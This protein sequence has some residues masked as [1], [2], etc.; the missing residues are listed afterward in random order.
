[1]KTKVG[2]LTLILLITLYSCN[3]SSDNSYVEKEAVINIDIAI[4]TVN[5]ENLKSELNLSEQEYSFEGTNDYELADVVNS[6]SGI[7]NVHT[8][9]SRNGSILTI[10]EI[11]ESNSIY[12]LELYLGYKL[13]SDENYQ[14]KEPISLLSL[15]YTINN[16]FF[17]VGLD[18]EIEK[19]LNEIENPYSDLKIVIIGKADFILNSTANLQIPVLVD[20]QLI[21]TRFELY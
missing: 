18:S 5:S 15:D 13:Q 6:L 11:G 2:F 19:L 1:M 14:T 16:G 3:E 7:M 12:S 10:P 9:R 8:I 20:S 21:E 4:T 17:Q